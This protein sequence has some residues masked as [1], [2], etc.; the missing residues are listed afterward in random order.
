ML[1]HLLTT[2]IGTRRLSKHVRIHGEY[3]RVSGTSAGVFSSLALHPQAAV[4]PKQRWGVKPFYR[5]SETLRLL[6]ATL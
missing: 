4:T 5:G 3:W 2:G 1:L 6:T